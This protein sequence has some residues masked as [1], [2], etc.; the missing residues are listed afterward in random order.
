M[1]EFKVV[2]KDGRTFI[3]K[4][5][6]LYHGQ[7]GPNAFTSVADEKLNTVFCV[8]NAEVLLAAQVDCVNEEPPADATEGHKSTI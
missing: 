8:Q 6:R 7:R 1:P 4:G 5:H 3:V 2:L